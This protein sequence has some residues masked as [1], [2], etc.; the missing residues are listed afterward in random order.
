MVLEAPLKKM[1]TGVRD[2]CHVEVLDE[3]EALQ[4]AAVPGSMDHEAAPPYG[5]SEHEVNWDDVTKALEMSMSSAV[6]A[7]AVKVEPITANGQEDNEGF[8]G[9]NRGQ[10]IK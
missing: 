10:L 2:S 5:S 4:A 6:A 7:S 1:K 8:G 9:A 3:D